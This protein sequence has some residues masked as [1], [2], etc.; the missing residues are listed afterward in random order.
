[1]VR[2][3]HKKTPYGY[4]GLG[5]FHTHL[6]GVV[7]IDLSYYWIRIS[8]AGYIRR[9]V[10]KIKNSNG[11]VYLYIGFWCHKVNTVQTALKAFTG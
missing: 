9:L 5:R 4:G 3:S 6:T 7:A 8:E 11:A 2:V 1:M 10:H